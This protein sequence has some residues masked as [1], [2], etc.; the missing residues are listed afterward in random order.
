[1]KAHMLIAIGILSLASP[2]FADMNSGAALLKNCNAAIKQADG[3]TLT[4]EES[5]GA[6]YCTGYLSGFM[7]SHVMEINAKPKKPLYCLPE[8]GLTNNKMA[9]ILTAY[10]KKHPE[11]SQESARLQVVSALLQSFPCKKS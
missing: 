1:M 4:E 9:H 7:D 11:R 5:L 3:G 10:F 8:T 2:T 6:V